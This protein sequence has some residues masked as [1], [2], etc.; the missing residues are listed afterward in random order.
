STGRDDLWTWY[1]PAIRVPSVPG[2]GGDVDVLSQ[3]TY[4]EPSPLRV[5]Y[6]ADE[7]LAM[8]RAAP[9]HPRRIMK[10]TQL[11]WY[12]STSAPLKS[13]KEYIAS[14]FDDHDPDAA[15]ISLAPMHLRESFW[16]KISRPV[17]G[18]MYHGWSSL[19][20]TDGTH[21]YK[22]T[23]PDLQTEFTRLHTRVLPPLAPLLAQLPDRPADV[24]YVNSFAAQVFARRGSYGYS[25]DEAFLTLLHAQLQPEV[26]FDERLPDGGLDR[27]GVIVLSDCDVL[28][29]PLVAQLRIFQDRGGIVIADPNVAPAIQPNL[30]L[31]RFVRT[32]Q[33]AA[34]KATILAN[35]QKLREQLDSRYT[36]YAES[37]NPELITRV[38]SA[39]QS[40][41][42]FLVNDRREFG[43]YV[44]QHGLVMEQGLPS[45]AT[46]SVLRTGGHV[47]DLLTSQPVESTSH[48]GQLHWRAA[49]GPCDGGLFL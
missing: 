25:H 4:T 46:V 26:L 2:S 44:G 8:A 49:V 30:V 22:Y 17:S 45:E 32:R 12:R 11:F 48:K 24:A 23:Q 19:V 31:P 14:P 34:D 3:W 38:R 28:T 42:V 29:E 47:Y 9:G 21:P 7:L 15:Y 33:T 41:Y 37:D 43:T 5:G 1:D 6:F 18:L 27:F 13:G 39:G 10:M 40:D 36:R 16:S 20:P 35:A